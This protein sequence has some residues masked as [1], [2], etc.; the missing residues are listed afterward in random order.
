MDKLRK[1]DFINHRQEDASAVAS[2]K[3]GLWELETFPFDKYFHHADSILDIGCNTGST[4]F[5]LY[6]KGFHHITGLDPSPSK[7]QEA[8]KFSQGE[9]MEIP[10]LLGSATKIPLKDSSFDHAFFSFHGLMKI[11]QRKNRILALKEIHRVLRPGGI[12][13]FT[14]PN[15][16]SNERYLNFWEQEEMIWRENKQDERLYEFGDI[17]TKGKPDE[18]YLHIPSQQEVLDCLEEAQ[19]TVLETFHQDRSFN[20]SDVDFSPDCHFWIVH[21]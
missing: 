17:F 13:L 11:P 5:A 6:K 8:R 2:K 9:N 21:K 10:F 19:L 16:D 14:T 12:F 18:A 4:A 15:R 1:D 3:R 20:G 7:I